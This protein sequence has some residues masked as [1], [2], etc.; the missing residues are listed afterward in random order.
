MKI[1]SIHERYL[2]YASNPDD[3]MYKELHPG[4]YIEVVKLDPGEFVGAYFCSCCD[5]RLEGNPD[6][7]AWGKHKETCPAAWDDSPVFRE[8]DKEYEP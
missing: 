3:P 1:L 6:W 4:G 5:K 2:A 8:L 7:R